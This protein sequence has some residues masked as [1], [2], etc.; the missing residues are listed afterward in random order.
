MKIFNYLAVFILLASCGNNDEMKIDNVS[1]VE[2]IN[3]PI[4][5]TLPAIDKL[6]YEF[7]NHSLLINDGNVFNPN[8]S[9]DLSSQ[10]NIVSKIV[11][12]YGGKYFTDNSAVVVG[13]FD[14]NYIVYLKYLPI[15]NEHGLQ[16]EDHAGDGL[17]FEVDKESLK[18][19]KMTFGIQSASQFV[20]EDNG[21]KQFPNWVDI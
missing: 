5:D 20:L 8:S 11:E 6:N 17:T 13:D 2:K 3:I 14:E 9:L 10:L 7:E 15:L 19:S 4:Y 18:I 21:F 16:I 1:V 12:S